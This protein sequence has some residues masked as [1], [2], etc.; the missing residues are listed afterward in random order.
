[1]ARMTQEPA[2]PADPIVA[3]RYRVEGWLGTGGQAVVLRVHD[4]RLG[5]PRA[6]KVLLP[7]SAR[8]A[9]LR[10]RFASEATTMAMLEHPNVLRV[11]DVA[12]ADGL[13]YYVM[14]LVEGGSLARRI[15][16]LGPLEARE[17][18][19]AALQVCAGLELAHARGVIHRDIKPQNVLVALDG[20][21]KLLDF[22]IARIE[23]HRRTR[24]G[25]ALGTE[26]YM[27]PEQ[28]RDAS[29]VDERAD[30]FSVG[31]L[32]YVMISGRDPVEWLAG[33]GRE[34][35]PS[36]LR[37]E[38]ERATQEDT[39][40]RHASIAELAEALGR[41]LA[42]LPA[43]ARSRLREVVPVTDEEEEDEDAGSEIVDWLAGMVIPERHA[44]GPRA[45]SADGHRSTP[46]LAAAPTIGPSPTTPDPG[47]QGR[48]HP[49]APPVARTPP[50][51]PYE[52]GV[53]A[54]SPLTVSPARAPEAHRPPVAPRVDDDDDDTPRWKLPLAAIPVILVGGLVLV[55]GSAQL[56]SNAMS[57]WLEQNERSAEVTAAARTAESHLHFAV[58]ADLAVVGALV[59]LGADRQALD[60]RVAAWEA[61]TREPDR[62]IAALALVDHLWS[63]GRQVAGPGS[64]HSAR[65]DPPLQRLRAAASDYRDTHHASGAAPRTSAQPAVVR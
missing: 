44:H 17:A 52:I 53:D 30:V 2:A 48:R 12:E 22:G 42:G 54:A 56:L 9:R 38:L 65:V 62:S 25:A 19:E 8:K 7:S 36:P 6:L 29:A 4:L 35:I 32:T 37:A 59:E 5:V 45:V 26:G 31:I 41:C 58:K 47:A 16:H 34:R 3:G 24:A 20:T 11:Y 28:A 64:P 23:D 63:T 51:Q 39:S 27:A 14:E 33:R 46:P 43:A 13:P 57:M 61:A 50:P 15:Q 18:V 55:G 60:E 1:M 21:C 49:S 10:E 40:Q